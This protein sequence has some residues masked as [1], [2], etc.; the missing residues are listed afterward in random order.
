MGTRYVCV[1]VVQDPR[2]PRGGVRGRGEGRGC[3]GVARWASRL[4][5]DLCRL[6]SPWKG[7]HVSRAQP[8]LLYSLE[9]RTSPRTY[10]SEQARI[11]RAIILCVRGRRASFFLVLV[12]LPRCFILHPRLIM[13]SWTIFFEYRYIRPTDS[14]DLFSVQFTRLLSTEDPK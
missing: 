7:P 13:G 11:A 3:V 12:T 5:S 6:S 1:T 14:Y 4:T 10:A 9:I 2:E 8:Y